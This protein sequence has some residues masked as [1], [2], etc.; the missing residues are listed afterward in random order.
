[1]L[2]NGVIVAATCAALC[3]CSS[4]NLQGDLPADEPI[5]TTGSHLPSRSANSNSV[6][7][8]APPTIDQVMK[9]QQC[10]GGPCGASK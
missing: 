3:G 5:Y 8:L 2:R 6:K 4:M 1:M 10:V 7:S 9:G